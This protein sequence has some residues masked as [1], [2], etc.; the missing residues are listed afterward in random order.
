MKTILQVITIFPIVWAVVESYV[1]VK[2]KGDLGGTIS[3]I[4]RSVICATLA[5]F[6]IGN[7]LQLP[8]Y[9]VLFCIAIGTG[10]WIWFDIAYNLWRN[11]NPF[12]IGTTKKYDKTARRFIGNDGLAYTA[13]K[14]VFYIAS[15]LFLIYT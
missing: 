6:V 12:Y 11:E 15:T 1:H 8:Y 9:Y 3:F 13:F 4:I 14:G 2:L 10:F 7:P 5:L